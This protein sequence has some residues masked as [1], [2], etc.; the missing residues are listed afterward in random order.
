MKD[1]LPILFPNI[2][3]AEGDYFLLPARVP[4]VLITRPKPKEVYED[5]PR[6]NTCSVNNCPLWSKYPTV[7]SKHDQEK[8]CNLSRDKRLEVAGPKTT[9]KL[10]GYTQREYSWAFPGV[11]NDKKEV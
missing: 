6:F 7:Y 11:R 4:R 5:C 10:L 1:E 9:L 2:H 3:L 8:R